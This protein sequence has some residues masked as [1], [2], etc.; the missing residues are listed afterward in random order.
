MADPKAKAP[1]IPQKPG[2]GAKTKHLEK[3]A[4]KPNLPIENLLD[5]FIRQSLAPDAN[6]GNNYYIGQVVGII[7]TKSNLDIYD[8]F[9]DSVS[10]M[11]RFF[12]NKQERENNN[13][14]KLIVHIPELFSINDIPLD[15]NKDILS[16]VTKFRIIY[17]GKEAIKKGDLVKIVFKNNK[18][19]TDPEVIS[20][21]TY[22]TIFNLF[23]PKINGLKD[24]LNAYLD[25]RV[26]Q[27]TGSNG[28]SANLNSQFYDLPKAG[29]FQLF[30][31]I[32][33]LTSTVGFE[34]WSDSRGEFKKKEFVDKYSS[35]ISY[36]LY[37]DNLVKGIAEA[38][39]IKKIVTKLLSV[40]N[41]DVVTQLDYE[42]YVTFFCS[43]TNDEDIAIF[44]D[45]LKFFITTITDKYSFIVEKVGADKNNNILIRIDTN[46]ASDASV[47]ESAQ[48]Y[49]QKSE[50]LRN[51]GIPSQTGQDSSVPQL[52]GSVY[53]ESKSTNDTC[54][55]PLP[56]ENSYYIDINN[57]S[58]FKRDTD[59]PFIEYFLNNTPTP[60]GLYG[61]KPC[62][63]NYII[64]PSKNSFSLA[65][66]NVALYAKNLMLSGELL[67]SKKEKPFYSFEELKK[68]NSKFYSIPENVKQKSPNILINS[69]FD[70]DKKNF[71]SE[72]AL[73]NR[74]NLLSNFLNRL[75]TL[76]ALNEFKNEKIPND[77]KEQ[78]VLILPINVV[79][80]KTNSSK[81]YK[82]SRHF[83][84]QAVDFVVYIKSGEKILQ[85]PP[86]VV[87]LYCRKTNIQSTY[88]VGHGIFFNDMYNHF[89]FSFLDMNE[90]SIASFQS[91]KAL[92]D[93]EK[94]NGRLWVVG[95]LPESI[96]KAK[97]APVQNLSRAIINYVSQKA[98]INEAIRR[99]IV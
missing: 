41:G 67:K 35:T 29:Y 1:N 60:N 42:V 56:Q 38:K 81:S 14:K 34:N 6:D 51:G 92:N 74:L 68:E 36:N 63:I 99:I 91:T 48:G 84:G 88:L 47:D 58:K 94:N 52:V 7:D 5:E 75:R 17:D 62:P 77:Q 26:S 13:V 2:N 55:N 86:E 31:E 59:R 32:K 37:C 79:R 30:D 70:D 71:I 83:F 89:E 21:Q 95:D 80:K 66:T 8:I 96:K 3:V 50:A 90:Q 12:A 20:I 15:T 11:E 76:I 28:S 4:V 45:Y 44:N 87:Y 85:I 61:T 46:L 40:D 19:F 49:V 78:K 43:S 25:C 27:L 24:K 93:D 53:I 54:V 9:T 33:L 39:G 65:F 97:D 73:A 18:T 23:E 10:N 72:D 69:N 98:G 82:F 64:G 16:Y 57:L 22:G